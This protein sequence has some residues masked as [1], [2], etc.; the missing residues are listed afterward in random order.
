M[1]APRD[2][3]TLFDAVT[4]SSITMESPCRG[5]LLVA[6]TDDGRFAVSPRM[7]QPGA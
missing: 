3:V 7:A 5:S 1:A 6:I 4:G 2:T